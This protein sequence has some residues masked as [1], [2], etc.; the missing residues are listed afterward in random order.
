MKTEKLLINQNEVW[1]TIESIK[2]QTE[3]GIEEQTNQFICYISYSE[4]IGTFG[5][6]LKNKNNNRKIFGSYNDAKKY[7]IEHLRIK[8]YPLNF[9]HPLEYNSTNV[10]EILYKNLLID[11]GDLE[12]TTK[13]IEGKIVKCISTSN[14]GNSIGS[15]TVEHSNGRME[16]Y[17]IMDIKKF[18]SA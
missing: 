9:H 12:N 15:I 18:K 7:A 2:L 11:I 6:P 10:F 13:T 17:S 1:I 3:N 14:D 16:T 4:P 5:T 8:L